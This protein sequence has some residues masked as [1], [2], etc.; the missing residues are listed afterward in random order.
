M[1]KSLKP[2][3]TRLKALNTFERVKTAIFLIWKEIDF[4]LRLVKFAPFYGLIKIKPII[5]N[6][7]AVSSK[8]LVCGNWK[9][10]IKFWYE[11]RF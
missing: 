8:A 1:K 5:S 4:S 7:K 10:M 9:K 2:R 3:P 11:R 6:K